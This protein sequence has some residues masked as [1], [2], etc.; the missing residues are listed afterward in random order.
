MRRVRRRPVDRSEDERRHRRPG[1]G[2]YVWAR[3]DES[4]SRAAA[5]P[6]LRLGHRHDAPWRAG[7]SKKKKADARDTAAAGSSP[8]RGSPRPPVGGARGARGRARGRAATRGSTRRRAPAPAARAGPRCGAAIST[9]VCRVQH[10]RHPHARPVHP[11]ASSAR[12]RRARRAAGP[13][14]GQAHDVVLRD[15]RVAQQPADDVAGADRQEALHRLPVGPARERLALAER[16]RATR[17]YVEGTR[18]L[19]GSAAGCRRR[20]RQVRAAGGRAAPARGGTRPPPPRAGPL[21]DV[22]RSPSR[23]RASTMERSTSRA[24]SSACSARA[25]TA[26]S[27]CAERRPRPRPQEQLATYAARSAASARERVARAAHRVWLASR[28]LRHPCA[29]HRSHGRGGRQGVQARR[30]LRAPVSCLWFRAEIRRPRCRS[31][32]QASHPPTRPSTRRE[33]SKSRSGR[34]PQTPKRYKVIFHNDDYTTMEF[35]VDV[36]TPLLPQER[37]RG[38]AHHADRAQEGKGRR[39]ASTRATSPRRKSPK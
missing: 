34:R 10:E 24:A 22:V 7:R 30:A 18:L 2:L 4:R 12:S 3:G 21:H 8:R 15:A 13:P 28:R 27:A 38:A 1:S 25:Q 36:L 11:L 37:D 32:A 33:T 19:R 26:S 35:V 29:V 9:A 20:A 16:E 17:P 39:R 31:A 5:L 23:F 14:R 6:V